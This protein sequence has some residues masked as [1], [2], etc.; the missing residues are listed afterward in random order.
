MPYNFRSSD[1]TGS[2]ALALIG[3]PVGAQR[4]VGDGVA[5]AFGGEVAAEAEHVR[6]G[7]Q[8]QVLELG[9]LAEAQTC[10]DV[11]AGVLTDRQIGEPVGRGDAPV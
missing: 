11:A 2:G 8:A 1:I 3:G 7:G 9:E 10:G 6:P 5:A 4:A